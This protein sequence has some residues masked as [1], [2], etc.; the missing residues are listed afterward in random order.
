M[1]Q[2]YEIA[3]DRAKITEADRWSSGSV[4]CNGCLCMLV[5]FGGL[6]QEIEREK[7]IGSD[8]G[9]AGKGVCVKGV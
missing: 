2:W 7:T 9:Q 8:R 1:V 4:V 6:G 5:L 3:V